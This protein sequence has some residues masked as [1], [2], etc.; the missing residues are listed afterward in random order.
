MSRPLIED[1]DA[2]RAAFQDALADVDAELVTVPGV[3]GE[4]SVRDLVAH[5][6]AWCDHASGALELA[7]EG[8]G[9]EFAYSSNDTDAMN[10]RFL[11]EGRSISPAQALSREE[12]A[13][14]RFR[15]RVAALDSSHLGL[16]LGNGDTLE[17]V[18]RYDGPDHYAEHTEQ[19]R[20]WFGT[21]DEDEEP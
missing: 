8:R 17:E 3:I 2:A 6:A 5:V 20:A 21:D 11:A 7:A 4:W 10:E 12:A 19:L 1:L 14:R 18:V 16:R 9:D 13:F 15:E